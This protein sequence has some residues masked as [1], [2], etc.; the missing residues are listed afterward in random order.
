MLFAQFYHKSTGW[1]PETLDYSGPRKLIPACGSDSVCV[2]DG[3]FGPDRAAMVARDHAARLRN[4]HPDY[5]CFRLMRGESF[6][7]ASI[8]GAMISL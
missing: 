6:S 7:R 2:I 3:R 4:I 8:V 5:E 1:N